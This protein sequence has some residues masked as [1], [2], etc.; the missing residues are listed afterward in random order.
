MSEWVGWVALFLVTLGVF[1]LYS[2]ASALRDIA[3]RMELLVPHASRED[4]G[5]SVWALIGPLNRIALALE[6][7]SKHEVDRRAQEHAMRLSRALNAELTKP[8][9]G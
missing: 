2:I 6:R 1:A 7:Q 5:Y 8:E 9:Q 3:A 4:G